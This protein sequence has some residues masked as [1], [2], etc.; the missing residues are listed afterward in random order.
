MGLGAH[1]FTVLSYVAS[2]RL[3]SIVGC[4]FTGL[5]VSGSELSFFFMIT[6]FSCFTD[7]IL[8]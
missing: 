3:R 7:I 6:F 5:L 1:G 2:R 4:S 8:V